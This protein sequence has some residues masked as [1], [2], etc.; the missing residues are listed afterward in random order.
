MSLWRR[1]TQRRG[2]A[3]NFVNAHL[4]RLAGTSGCWFVANEKKKKKY[5]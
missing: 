3:D 4:A 1:K 2:G 5:I